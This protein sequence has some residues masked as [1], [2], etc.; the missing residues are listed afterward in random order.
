M[1]KTASPNGIIDFSAWT[2][3]QRRYEWFT[4]DQDESE[5]GEPFRARVQRLTNAEVDAIPLDNTP[6]VDLIV[7]H[8]RYFIAW[9]LTAID[10]ATG[11][12][13][14]VPPPAE[15]DEVNCR[16]VLDRLLLRDQVRFLFQTMTAGHMLKM[17]SEKKALLRSVTSPASSLED[18]SAGVT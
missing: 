9:N 10:S 5:A 6:I 3:A 14:S 2:P 8:R 11:K 7:T 18:G 16:T 12:T 1:P 17:V 15:L 4:M 13:R